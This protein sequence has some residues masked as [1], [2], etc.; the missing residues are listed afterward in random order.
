[1]TVEPSPG[2]EGW[3]GSG[4]L[5]P[6][7][8]LHEPSGRC[9]SVRAQPR[10]LDHKHC[11]SLHAAR[12]RDGDPAR[13]RRL[14]APPGR[15]Q[16]LGGALGPDRRQRPADKSMYFD[17]METRSIGIRASTPCRRRSTTCERDGD[18]HLAARAARTCCAS[19]DTCLVLAQ[20]LSGVVRA[21]ADRR[22]GHRARQHRARPAR[23]GARAAGPRRAG[24]GPGRDEDAL[25][26]LREERDCLNVTMA[27]LPRGDFARHR[28]ARGDAGDAARAAVAAPAAADASADAE[29]AAIAAKAVKEARYHRRHA[30]DWVLRLADG[31]AESRQRTERALAELWPTPPVVR[32]RDAVDD[33]AAASG[34]GPRWADLE[35]RLAAGDRANC[36]AEAGLP[37]GRHRVS[38]QRG[39]NGRQRAHGPCS[40]RCSTCSAPIPEAR[41]DGA[42]ILGRRARLGGARRGVRPRGA[43]ASRCATSGRHRARRDR[44]R[45]GGLEVVLTPTY[46]GCPATEAIADDVRAAI[47]AA[48][49]GDARHAAPRAGL[50]DRL[51][52]ERGAQ[53]RRLWHRAAGPAAQAGEAPRRFAAPLVVPLPALRQPQH[54]APVGVRL[55]GVQGAAPV[56]SPCGE[57]FEHFKAI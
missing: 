25:A 51:D 13:A 10:R 31:T 20:R 2:Q 24:R 5:R 47:A 1:M 32:A 18:R 12:R 28:A 9:G 46:S 29:L 49:L 40:P 44:R 48:G 30:G 34:L 3:G 6:P 53:V 43:R 19:A 33:A 17:P 52:H 56:P 27:E 55:D 4:P 23:P 26:F 8:R 22:G 45:Q 16:R 41:G 54:R 35:A 37:P 14:H 36:S 15:Q 38:Q 57:P 11:G 39:R 21:R 42:A 50:D 7:D